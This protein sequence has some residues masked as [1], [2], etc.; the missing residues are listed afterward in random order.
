MKNMVQSLP[1]MLR[2]NWIPRAIETT[3]C[4]K[5]IRSNIE[6]IETL[7]GNLELHG[8]TQAEAEKAVISQVVAF[9]AL[10]CRCCALPGEF[11]PWTRAEKMKAIS[12]QNAAIRPKDVLE[13]LGREQ[14]TEKKDR[15][16]IYD[17]QNS[18]SIGRRWTQ[19]QHAFPVYLNAAI[20]FWS[21]SPDERIPPLC[22]LSDGA[23]STLFAGEEQ[24][25]DSIRQELHRAGLYRPKGRA[26][27]YDG[28]NFTLFSRV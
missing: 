8:L 1:A 20:Q 9:R 10:C 15:R 18:G 11:S 12:A 23:I 5:F 2:E 6:L 13:W 26:F 4:A 25:L 21:T 19:K 16:K 22:L 27:S 3:D 14:R 17:A 24:G 28:M 7:T